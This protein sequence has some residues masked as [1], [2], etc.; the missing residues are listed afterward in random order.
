MHG[1]AQLPV[2]LCFT[3]R[4]KLVV[5][6]LFCVFSV[7]FLIVPNCIIFGSIEKMIRKKELTFVHPG[8]LVYRNLH[9]PQHL[10]SNITFGG[11]FSPSAFIARTTVKL[12]LLPRRI[13]LALFGFQ[14]TPVFLWLATRI[15][16]GF[17]PCSGFGWTRSGNAVW[18]SARSDETPPPCPPCRLVGA[19]PKS[20]L[21]RTT[22]VN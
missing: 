14:W 4:L 22:W 16:S 10:D 5:D 18:L 20:C 21:R 12:C 6:W 13:R 3:V 1:W 19:V 15:L 8:L 17:R 9:S 11:S 7:F 2:V